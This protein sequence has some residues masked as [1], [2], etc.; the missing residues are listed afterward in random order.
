[1]L[2]ENIAKELNLQRNQ[3][4]DA[5]DGQEIKSVWRIIQR[6][7]SI[8]GDFKGST[9]FE[10]RL[11]RTVTALSLPQQLLDSEELSRTILICK[12]YR[13]NPIRMQFRKYLLD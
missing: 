8:A 9:Q 12:I 4:N 2:N 6:N 7:F 5:S 11:A 13:W 10:F 1:M 3:E